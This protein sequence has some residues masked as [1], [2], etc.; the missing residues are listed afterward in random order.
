MPQRELADIF[1]AIHLLR[2]VPKQTKAASRL[3]EL[4]KVS[5]AVPKLEGPQMWCCTSLYSH[6]G[7]GR[8]VCE[9]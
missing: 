2:F 3:N 7:P 5:K 4:R 1:I 8:G 9:V 6:F